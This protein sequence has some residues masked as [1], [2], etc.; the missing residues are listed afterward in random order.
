MGRFMKKSSYYSNS[1]Y[2]MT[3]GQQ[4]TPAERPQNSWV[5]LALVVG[6]AL[7]ITSYLMLK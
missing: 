3:G 1:G 4:R 5:G 7:L 2:R 6:C